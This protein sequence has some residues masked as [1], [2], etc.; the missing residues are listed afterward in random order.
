[1]T[2]TELLISEAIKKA[3]LP[4]MLVRK[5]TT[6]AGLKVV[7]RVDEMIVTEPLTGTIQS[8]CDEPPPFME[9]KT[10]VYPAVHID[11][12]ISRLL[13]FDESTARMIAREI[14]HRWEQ[15]QREAR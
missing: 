10:K 8:V 15:I 14:E 4:V 1:M 11:L 3:Q 13:E 2:E 9:I 12:E 6:E 7:L 5:E